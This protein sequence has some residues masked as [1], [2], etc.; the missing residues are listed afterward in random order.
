MLWSKPLLVTSR[1]R[2]TFCVWSWTPIKMERLIWMNFNAIP[3]RRAPTFDQLDTNKDGWLSR[4]E[5]RQHFISPNGAEDL[6][7]AKSFIAEVMKN[8]KNQAKHSEGILESTPITT[9]M[10]SEFE[11]SLDFLCNLLDADQNGEIDLGEFS[12]MYPKVGHHLFD[13]LDTDKDGF[14]SKDELRQHFITGGSNDT[15]KVK[16]FISEVQK[17]LKA[18]AALNRETMSRINEHIQ[19]QAKKR[20]RRV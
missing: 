1:E 14:L 2:L 3:K 6:D 18:Q 10:K 16:H 4:A 8:L 17:N 9:T 19:P 12:L 15:A 20:G 7:K 11:A 13:H 5:L